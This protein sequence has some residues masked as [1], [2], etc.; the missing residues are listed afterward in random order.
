MSLNQVDTSYTQQVKQLVSHYFD[1]KNEK[2]SVVSDAMAYFANKDSKNKGSK[3][4]ESKNVTLNNSEKSRIARVSSLNS[5]IS[6]LLSL[7]EGDSLEETQ[8]NTAK[9]LGTLLLITDHSDKDFAKHHQIL[10]PIY[11]AALS[12]RLCDDL[13]NLGN[14]THRYLG[15]YSETTSRYQTD[16]H[17][18]ERWRNELAFPLVKAALLQD[19][20]L[21]HPA[22]IDLLHGDNDKL[23]EFRLL[24]E[25]ERKTLLK[26]N[27][28]YSLD[29][30]ENAIG[31]SPYQANSHE[32]KDIKE[33]MEQEAL[34]F[35][36]ETI[37]DAT[38]LQNHI[39]DLIKIPQIY[40]S[41]VLSTKS[42][43][44]KKD[45][46]KGYMIIE[47]LMKNG[48]LEKRIAN[49]FLQMVGY[50]P[51]GFGISFIANDEHGNLKS[52]YEF[53]IVN[54]LY[55]KT[56]AEPRVRLVTRN[57]TFIRSS[58]DLVI[59]RDA[60]LFFQS[61]HKK[62]LTINKERL[63]EILSNLTGGP[64]DRNVNNLIPK[65]WEPF[66]YFS[67]KQNQNLWN[68]K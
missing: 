68:G 34:D 51:Q 24:D 58:K 35:T 1:P 10:K 16:S 5:F 44:D 23:N 13:L 53:A 36:L 59:S 63:N 67:E 25:G 38:I 30:V 2:G 17:W 6:Q 21:Y 49:C 37:K 65:L 3:N 11:K 62:L 18:G 60:N 41:F 28:K 55:P 57:L 50:F 54:R 61:N 29:Y 22:S 8:H 56:A 14:V 42:N 40:A 52:D 26:L 31:F 47:Q 19:I 9:F 64:E 45:L 33:L 4:K 15:K 7:T 27:L 48:T 46:P 66:D 12:L 20:G 39:G 32:E 43:Y